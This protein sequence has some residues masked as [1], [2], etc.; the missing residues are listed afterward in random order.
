MATET[1]PQQFTFQAEISQLLHLLSH[2]LYQNREIAI[3]ELVSNAS[4][5]LDKFRHVSLTQKEHEDDAALRISIEPDAENRLLTIRDNGIGMTH[6]ELIQNLGTIAHSGSL[7]YLKKLGENSKDEVSLIGQFGVGFYSSFMLA[8]RVEVLS[9]SYQEDTGWKWESDGSGQFTIEPAEGLERGTQVR[10]HLKADLKEFTEPVRLKHILTEYS[11]FV[12][13]AIHLGDEHVNDQPPIWVEPK[14]QVTE[15]QYKNFYGYLSKRTYEEPLWHLHLTS[16]SPFQF[17]AVLFCPTS[18]FELLGFGKDEHGLS[19][20]AKR[21]LVQSNCRELLPEYLR[22]IYGLVD[23]ADLPLN[24]SRQALQDDTV[25]RKI[26]KVLV[27]K[28]FSHLE[29]IAKDSPDDYGKFYEQFGSTLREGVASDFENR[30]TLAKLLRFRSS[31]GEDR[32]AVISLD[33]YVSR[34]PDGQKQIFYVGGETIAN[35][36]K[37]PNLEAF[38]SRNLEVLYLIDPVDEFVLNHVNKFEDRD[39]VSIDSSDVDLP[40]LHSSGDS[41]DTDTAKEEK[42]GPPAGFGTVLNLFRESLGD[43]V[44][45]VR[46]S[47][48]L[49]SSAC[50]LVNPEG[51]MSAQLQKVLSRA[52]DE[53]HLTKRILEVNPAHPLVKHLASLSTNDEHTA[54][55]K[56]CGQQF[57][58]NAMLA[59]GVV[60]DPYETAERMLG[61]MEELAQQR[62]PIAGG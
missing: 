62:S 50:C 32:A 47:K 22:F 30:N 61:F 41:E 43:K 21:I 24:V 35:I 1:A 37:N 16:D 52:S 49:T 2:S 3:R 54:F 29:D 7:E 13:Y 57:F 27:K 14:S 51:S 48:R 18:N 42:S 34:I 53:F 12:P 17:H 19:L 45:D 36:E 26:R 11:T 55:I 56:T 8:D 40:E 33:D 23:S 6:D 4:D 31:H 38:R 10:L 28:V 44:E 59:E 60:P 46:E 9:R 20:C 58:A 25:F 15:E 39:L 5:A